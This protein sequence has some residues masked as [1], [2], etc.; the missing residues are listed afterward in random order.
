MEVETEQAFEELGRS[1]QKLSPNAYATLI[2]HR[3]EGLT[4]Q[5]IGDR[6]GVSRAQVKKYLARALLHVRQGLGELSRLWPGNTER[7]EQLLDPPELDLI[8]AAHHQF[9]RD[10]AGDFACLRGSPECPIDVGDLRH[11]IAS[12]YVR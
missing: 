1:L 3:C 12:P 8:A 5:Q 4:L 11:D 10:H 9:H 7:S 6:L 2:L